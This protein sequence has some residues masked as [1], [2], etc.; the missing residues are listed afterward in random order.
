MTWRTRAL[1]LGYPLVEL[2]T[3]LL[4]AGALGWVWTIALLVIAPAI[5]AFVSLPLAGGPSTARRRGLIVAA[6]DGATGSGS[7][8]SG[9]EMPH[10]RK[11]DKRWQKKRR[12]VELGPDG[13]P[14]APVHA[15]R[16][17]RK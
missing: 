10:P 14:V 7:S 2:V 15:P 8:N 5:H 13:L 16:Q 1:L 9:K 12:R 3:I 17:M 11:M 4:V 6:A